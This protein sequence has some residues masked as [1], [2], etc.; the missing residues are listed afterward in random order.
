MTIGK[1]E[2]EKKQTLHRVVKSR[3]YV[4]NLR[5]RDQKKHLFA[6]NEQYYSFYFYQKMEYKATS[7]P[8]I[9]IAPTANPLLTLN[10]LE[11]ISNPLD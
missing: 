4:Y 9:I 5:Y 10:I 2:E 6:L 3:F 7:T 8:L 11:S 1:G